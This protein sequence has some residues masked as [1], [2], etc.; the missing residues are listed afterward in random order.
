MISHNSVA[1]ALSREGTA[2]RLF[3]N[4]EKLQHD[5]DVRNLATMMSDGVASALSHEDTAARFFLNLEK[6][7]SDFDVKI[8]D[9]AKIMCGSVAS[10]WTRHIACSRILPSSATHTR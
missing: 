9:V 7:W 1:S 4:L 5:F 2:P 8:V 3:L 6:L 10:A